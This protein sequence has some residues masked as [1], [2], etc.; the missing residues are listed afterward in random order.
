MVEESLSFEQLLGEY[1]PMIHNL[2]N[3]L[4]IMDP[5]KEFFQEGVLALWE[6]SQTYDEKKG[7]RSTFTYFIIRNR[8]IS[9]IR[10]K[11]R[12]QEQIEEIMVKSTNEATIGPH[13]FEWDP[14]LYQEIISKLSK[15]QRKWFDGFVIE[16][17]SIKEIALR[18][19]VTVDAVK[20]WG[21]LAKRKLMKE[22]V[23]LAYLE[24]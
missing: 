10:K 13:E 21:R 3:R 4:G 24:I 8:L 20:N 5:H 14:Y 1:K 6:V 22:P 23:V 12:K 18:E 9:L 17:L 2:I 15:N 7:K 19:Q 11:N 16:D